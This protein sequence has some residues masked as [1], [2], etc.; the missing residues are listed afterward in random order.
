MIR[1]SNDHEK[2]ELDSEACI[3]SEIRFGQYLFRDINSFDIY[4]SDKFA[5]IVALKCMVPNTNLLKIRR[6]D[7]RKDFRPITWL[8]ERRKI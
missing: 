8:F 6:R 2:T 7:L 5:Y 3:A 1:P 4:M